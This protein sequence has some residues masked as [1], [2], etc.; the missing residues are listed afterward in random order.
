MAEVNSYSLEIAELPSRSNSKSGRT[1]SSARS[2]KDY[3]RNRYRA[4]CPV[5]SLVVLLYV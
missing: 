3:L 5:N 1:S 2:T 4:S